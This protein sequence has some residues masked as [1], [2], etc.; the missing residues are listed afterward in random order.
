M[1]EPRFEAVKILMQ[2]QKDAAYSS[3]AITQA[4][5]EIHFADQRDTAFTV[6]LIYG[7]LENKLTL[8]Y[9]ISLY[10]NDKT[11]RLKSNVKNILRVGAYQLLYLDKIPQS[12]A[13]NEAVKITK[14]L[15]AKYATGLVNAVLRRIAE[16]GKIF[17]ETD[18]KNKDISIKYSV[19]IDIVDNFVK[20]YGTEKA[21][22]IFACFSGRRP[23]Y[24]RHNLL[25]CSEEEL[26]LSLK[27]EGIT[28]NS[29]DLEGCFSVENT[30]D[31]TKLDAFKKGYF[32]VQD[33]SS[34]LCCS[35]LDVKPGDFVVDCCA[36]PG[37]KSFTL[38][39]FLK[40]EGRILSCDIHQHK[41]QLI[42][43]TAE[44]LGIKNLDT[45]C[46]DAREL[47]R[48]VKEADRVLCDVPCSGF[49]VI[50]R[51]PEIRYKRKQDYKELPALQ[52]DILFSCAEMVR[53]GGTLI[54]STCTLNIAENENVCE[55]FLKDFP[56]FHIADD[57]VY[58]S[59]TDRFLTVFPDSCSGDGFFIA[60]FTRG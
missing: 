28:V 11:M 51:K 43:K 20:D 15:G 8:D 45:V 34:Q 1:H 26:L 5:K 2:I 47:I 16:N 29:T 48:D 53:S 54:Y 55:A 3:L 24:I 12:A 60:K 44:R 17:P 58:R 36:A 25:K 14:A 9:N 32:Y 30:G 13:V 49:G 22:S 42:K 37:G 10:L 18:N 19:G 35:L 27:R 56:D 52:K 41:T 4:L 40:N 46:C 21:E 57:M 50:G 31:M 6:S 23:I 7:V 33:M 38:S 39:Q 59:L